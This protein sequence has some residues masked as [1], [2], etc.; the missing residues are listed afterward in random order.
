MKNKLV[1]IIL[2]CIVFV[3]SGCSNEVNDMTKEL[4]GKYFYKEC[5]YLNL[6]SSST[7]DY[8]TNLYKQN[9]YID[10]GEKELSYYNSESE[11]IEYKNVEFIENELDNEVDSVLNLEI[12]DV[13]DDFDIRYD[14]YS[15]NQLVS[16]VVFIAN[17]KVYLAET[18][19]IGG[20]N[21]ILVIWSIFEI[22]N[23]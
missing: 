3:L 18:R 2:F 20:S 15:D 8:Q 4:S 7:L 6:L 9:V 21:N 1:L 12:N 23:S 10:F 14:I 22:D 17:Q 16:L 5:V 13:L 19:M 11:L